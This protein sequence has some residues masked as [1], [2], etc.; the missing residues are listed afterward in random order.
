MEVSG[1]ISPGFSTR[2]KATHVCASLFISPAARLSVWTSP[3]VFQICKQIYPLQV[4]MAILVSKISTSRH[5][6]DTCRFTMEVHHD[7]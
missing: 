2:F 4:C 7:L 3:P 1:E 6:N 5:I